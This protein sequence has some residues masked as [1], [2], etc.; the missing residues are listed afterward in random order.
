MIGFPRSGSL[1]VAV[2]AALALMISACSSGSG[3]EEPSPAAGN[4]ADA[5]EPAT[6][7]A[8]ATDA[9]DSDDAVDPAEAERGS[10]EDDVEP[11]VLGAHLGYEIPGLDVGDS[12]ELRRIEQE[13]LAAC[14]A[15][16]G[17][18]YIAYLP[19]PATIYVP[20]QDGLDPESREFAAI[21]GFGVSTQ[22]YAQRDVGPGLLGHSGDGSGYAFE[23]NPN[24]V[25]RAGLSPEELA[26]YDRAF[27]GADSPY[28]LSSAEQDELEASGKLVGRLITAHGCIGEAQRAIDGDASDVLDV[29]AIEI[30]TMTER[31]YSDDR[32]LAYAADVERCVHQAG[33]DFYA[34]Q[35]AWATLAHFDELVSAVDELVGGDPFEELT[36][37]DLAALSPQ[38]IDA[39]YDLPRDVG[40]EARN[41]LA[42]IQDLEVATATTVWDCGG[43]A[44]EERRVINDILAD[45]Q[46]RFIEE[47]RSELEKFRR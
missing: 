11:S 39:L 31:A 21:Y 13:T 26:A 34:N 25:V 27:W 16:E 33:Y 47:H 3:S 2:V 12:A 10:T 18:T 8:V 45:L 6:G 38:E 41:R 20:V 28:F 46:A 14:M 40:E 17:F 9:D 42:E 24:E 32:Y 5:N 43:S 35:P 29:F 15:R 22:F 44:D 36:D 19:D 7:P 37:A 1:G 30:L 4:Q 23:E